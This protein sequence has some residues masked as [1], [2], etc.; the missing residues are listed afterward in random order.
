MLV[1]YF[2][3]HHH[4]HFCSL[5]GPIGLVNLLTAKACGASK[6]AI[7]G[8]ISHSLIVLFFNSLSLTFISHFTYLFMTSD[9]DESRLAKAKELG[10]DYTIKV[11][12]RDGKEVAKKVMEVM[13]PADKTIEC[14]GVESSIHTG[15]YVSI[16]DDDTS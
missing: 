15:I 3:H 2:Y 5:V 8:S 14:T 1:K 16:D 10:A 6:V 9:L 12:S 11:E 4:H 7:T 13:G